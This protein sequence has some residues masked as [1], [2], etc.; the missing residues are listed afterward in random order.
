MLTIVQDRERLVAALRQRGVDYLSPSNAALTHPIDDETLLASLAAHSEPRIRQALVALFLVEPA[1]A[2][3][4]PA[5]RSLL[6]SQ[7]AAHLATY[8][9]AA[10]YLQRMWWPRLSRYLPGCA[11]LPDYG[12]AEL[13][14]PS[15]EEGHGK[16]GLYALA[17]REKA[18]SAH[19]FN[20]L[21]EF[22]GV[23]ALVLHS[24]QQRARAHELS[25]QR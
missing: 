3:K 1:L 14:L 23:A 15:P 8:Y 5:L 16:V 12:S 25:I 6:D 18:R 21:S 24:L 9:T 17:E 22:E 20:V 7:V 2:S 10:V 13:G 11:E 4:L 19:R